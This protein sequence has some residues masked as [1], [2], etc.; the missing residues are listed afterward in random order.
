MNK[1]YH[2]NAIAH[3]PEELCEIEAL[4]TKKRDTKKAA[5]KK[6][7]ESIEENNQPELI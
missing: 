6:G 4:V 2:S 5:K 3:N 1:K 7:T